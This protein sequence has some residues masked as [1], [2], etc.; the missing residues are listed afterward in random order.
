VR[1]IRYEPPHRALES[2][3]C[4]KTHHRQIVHD[5]GMAKS[6]TCGTTLGNGAA[7]GGVTAGTSVPAAAAAALV[8]AARM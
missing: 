3:A 1:E 5:I 6:T 8:R 7:A 4:R 2:L